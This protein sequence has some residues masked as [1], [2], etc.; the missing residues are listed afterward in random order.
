MIAIITLVALL[1][2]FIG[3][4]VVSSS[5]IGINDP[6]YIKWEYDGNQNT[7]YSCITASGNQRENVFMINSWEE[8]CTYLDI[9][10]QNRRKY[11]NPGAYGG[12]SDDSLIDAVSEHN[13]VPPQADFFDQYNLA[14]VDFCDPGDL[15]LESH[16]KKVEIRENTVS[17]TIYWEALAAST[18]DIP[19]NIYWIQVPKDC[20]KVSATYDRNMKPNP[21]WD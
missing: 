17:I 7:M 11:E 12:Y 1:A 4:L 5:I 9:T 14:V 16:I 19:G 8:Y 13:M 21:L 18:A 20:T 6:S 10:E 3:I 15:H 2:V